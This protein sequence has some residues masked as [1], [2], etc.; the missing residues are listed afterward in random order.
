MRGPCRPRS[1]RS[2]DTTFAWIAQANCA[3]HGVDQGRQQNE[4]LGCSIWLAW[5][6]TGA[7]CRSSDRPD[8]R[9]ACRVSA[10][11]ERSQLIERRAYVA[12]CRTV[13]GRHQAHRYPGVS[14]LSG[15]RAACGFTMREAMRAGHSALAGSFA[16]T[17]RGPSPATTAIPTTTAPIQ[18]RMTCSLSEKGFLAGRGRRGV[19]VRPLVHSRGH[20]CLGDRSTTLTIVESASNSGPAAPEWLSVRQTV[21]SGPLDTGEDLPKEGRRWRMTPVTGEQSERPGRGGLN[22][23]GASPSRGAGSRPGTRAPC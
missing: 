16:R 6:R 17:T 11:R 23:A 3:G 5:S 4:V 8:Q 10:G 2:L 1:P 22:A 15:G 18:L 9:T 20:P 13:S 7:S 14:V 12:G 21:G 19:R